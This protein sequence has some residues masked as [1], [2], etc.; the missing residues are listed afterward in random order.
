MHRLPL[1]QLRGEFARGGKL[2]ELLLLF[3]SA[4]LMQ[5]SQTAACIDSTRSKSDWRGG[6]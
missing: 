1:T 2:Q 6:S 4:F 5:I 3:M